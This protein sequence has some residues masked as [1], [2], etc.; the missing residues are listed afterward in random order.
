MDWTKNFGQKQVGR[1][2]SARW[3]RGVETVAAFKIQLLA[4]QSLYCFLFG[5]KVWERQKQANMTFP[6]PENEVLRCRIYY[7]PTDLKPN[8]R[9]I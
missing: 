6:R 2:L 9:G 3:E 4:F 8:G 7:F 1:K 5:Y